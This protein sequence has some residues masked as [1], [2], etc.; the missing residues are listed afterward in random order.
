MK[1]KMNEEAVND[2]LDLITINNLWKV[3]MY[4]KQIVLSQTLIHMANEFW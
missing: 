1:K 2:V 4:S 3:Y